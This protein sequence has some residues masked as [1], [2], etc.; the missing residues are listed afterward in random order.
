MPRYSS[1]PRSR[2]GDAVRAPCWPRARAQQPTASARPRATV[3]GKKKN[4]R[5][6]R[7]RE[8]P[9]G[10]QCGA[11]QAAHAQ[12]SANS[13]H[14]EVYNAAALPERCA[15]GGHGAADGHASLP[16]VECARRPCCAHCMRAL[17]VE[18]ERPGTLVVGDAGGR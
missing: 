8:T 16:R 1:T 2:F 14:G 13:S 7:Q 6:D 9:A 11:V 4:M 3:L 12:R 5:P 18:R 15:R 17:A 10:W